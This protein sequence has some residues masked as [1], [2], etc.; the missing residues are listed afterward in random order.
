M[1]TATLLFFFLVFPIVTFSQTWYEEILDSIYGS[2]FLNSADWAEYDSCNFE[3]SCSFISIDTSISNLWQI[4]RPQKNYFDTAYVGTKSLLTDTINTYSVGDSSVFETD[5]NDYNKL[6]YGALYV[7]EFTHKIDSDT[8][9]DGGIVEIFY[10]YGVGW[11]NIVD[12]SEYWGNYYYNYNI[13]QDSDTLFNGKRGFSG[14]ED[15]VTSG[16]IFD[17][18]SDCCNGDFLKFRFTFIS[19]SIDNPK[20]GWMIDNIKINKY[21]WSWSVPEHYKSENILKIY[22]NPAE[23]N[24]VVELE[25]YDNS[26]YDVHLFDSMGKEVRSLTGLSGDKVNIERN[27]LKNGL[28]HVFIQQNGVSIGMGKIIFQ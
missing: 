13:Y 28:Y 5:M 25:D 27:E 2:N 15:W 24:V 3:N 9:M 4:G 18:Y 21:L 20:D 7:L 22:P 6:G 1:K 17:T 14:R 26:I 19:D 10:D 8:L 11:Q 12:S 16:V 23:T